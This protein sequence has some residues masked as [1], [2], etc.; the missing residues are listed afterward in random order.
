MLK[1]YF[2]SQAHK[3]DT[4]HT[5]LHIIITLGKETPASM[6]AVVCTVRNNCMMVQNYAHECSIPNKLLHTFILCIA[7][8]IKMSQKTNPFAHIFADDGKTPLLTVFLI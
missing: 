2:V 6:S 8:H 1:Q 4:Y 3:K 5:C 7:M